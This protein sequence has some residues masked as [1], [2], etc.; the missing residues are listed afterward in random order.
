L[1]RDLYVHAKDIHAPRAVC[2]TAGT[3]T[4]QA[5]EFVEARMIDLVEKDNLV[6]MLKKL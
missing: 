1:L 5:R 2:I 6:K 3:V 4:E